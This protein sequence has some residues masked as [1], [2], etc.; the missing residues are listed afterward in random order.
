ML[1]SNVLIMILFGK[2]MR[3]QIDSKEGERGYDKPKHAFQL[4]KTRNLGSILSGFFFVLNDQQVAM[5]KI[6]F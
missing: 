6:L 3:S 2:E 1:P 5:M 4:Q